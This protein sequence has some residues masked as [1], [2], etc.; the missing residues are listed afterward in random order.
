MP[1]TQHRSMLVLA[2]ALVAGCRC[3]CLPETPPGAVD[4]VRSLVAAELDPLRVAPPAPRSTDGPVPAPALRLASARAGLA[5]LDEQVA[6]ATATVERLTEAHRCGCASDLQLSSAR[7]A[8][9]AALLARE[10]VELEVAFPADAERANDTLAAAWRALAAGP[11]VARPA[12][13]VG[14]AAYDALVT[15]NARV[16]PAAEDARRLAAEA[17]EQGCVSPSEL[18]GLQRAV[19]DVERQFLDVRTRLALARA[20][21][22]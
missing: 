14:A 10:R 20:G 6:I 21:V 22:R 17:L 13:R 2:V 8:R 9:E 1:P 15:L 18:L 7:L 3:H 12:D 19:F 11:A 4:P 5:L 16:L